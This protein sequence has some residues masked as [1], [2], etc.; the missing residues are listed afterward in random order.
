MKEI[1]SNKLL[2]VLK[3]K[4]S[5]GSSRSIHLNAIPSNSRIKLQLF[6][7]NKL[8]RK[9]IFN[10]FLEKLTSTSNLKFSLDFEKLDIEKHK[11]TLNRLKNLSRQNK[12]Y[13]L[14]HGLEPFG[15]GY[16]VIAKRDLKN[17]KKIIY[18][19]LL[20]WDLQLKENTRKL[21]SYDISRSEDSPIK[22]NEVFLNYIVD[23]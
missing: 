13:S 7:L 2:T 6:D 12:D 3:K 5:G 20:I 17:K 22:I 18:S 23:I 1:L 15:F 16:P 8:S 21:N 9:N 14:E 10:D 19:P 11:K 4:L